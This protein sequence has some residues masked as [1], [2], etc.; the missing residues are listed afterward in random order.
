MGS[1]WTTS[2]VVVALWS[3]PLRSLRWQENQLGEPLHIHA[4]RRS[5]LRPRIPHLRQRPHR[6][7]HLRPNHRPRKRPARLR[8]RDR[9]RLPRR[10]ARVLRRIDD[11]HGQHHRC[12]RFLRSVHPVLVTENARARQLRRVRRVV[13]A[14][15]HHVHDNRR[16]HVRG[17]RLAGGHHEYAL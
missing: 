4:Q 17:R 13:S 16:E 14:N 8:Q 3:L 7:G 1:R 10:A 9:E 5:P 6:H 2:R 15:H 12:R 11:L